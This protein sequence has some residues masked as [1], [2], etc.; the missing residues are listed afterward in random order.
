[1]R[2]DG[3]YLNSETSD[4]SKLLPATLFVKSGDSPKMDSQIRK[5]SSGDISG[6]K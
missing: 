4:N 6:R 2:V 1:M 5:M 3:L